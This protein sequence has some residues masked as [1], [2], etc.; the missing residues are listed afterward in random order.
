MRINIL[1]SAQGRLCCA[2]RIDE[3]AP[4]FESGGDSMHGSVQS[5]CVDSMGVV[6]QKAMASVIQHH[7]TRK[8][9]KLR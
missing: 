6:T 1:A 4:V 3:C 5:A 8:W 2:S 9:K 7:D